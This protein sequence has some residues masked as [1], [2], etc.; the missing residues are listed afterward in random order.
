[1][2]RF[3]ISVAFLVHSG[4]GVVPLSFFP[5]QEALR[6]RYG[7]EALTE[8][9]PGELLCFRRLSFTTVFVVIWMFSVLARSIARNILVVRA[10]P[11]IV[12][13]ATVQLG[14]A[15]AV[16]LEVGR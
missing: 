5:Q 4:G 14:A 15:V 6:N 10:V 7:G 13:S 3:V 11:V 12:A 1:M 9:F 8:A 2:A 16:P